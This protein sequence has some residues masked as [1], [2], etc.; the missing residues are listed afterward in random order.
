MGSYSIIDFSGQYSQKQADITVAQNLV[1]RFHLFY[2]GVNPLVA[3]V[4]N[5]ANEL[6]VA[7]FYAP[8]FDGSLKGLSDSQKAKVQEADYA[9]PFFADI[10]ALMQAPPALPESHRRFHEL[11]LHQYFPHLCG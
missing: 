6:Q 4:E 7:V 2:V 9:A 11:G 3:V 5:T 10:S 8:G 1:L